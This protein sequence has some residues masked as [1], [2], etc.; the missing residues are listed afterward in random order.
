MK[1]F[2]L[3]VGLLS[4]AGTAMAA[5]DCNE[6]KSEIDAKIK[7]NGVPAYSL[8]IVDKGA[9]PADHTVVGSCGGGTKEIAYK[10]G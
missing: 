7:V 5:K 1:K 8:E 10:R 3:A 4:I 9:V 2:L 6:L